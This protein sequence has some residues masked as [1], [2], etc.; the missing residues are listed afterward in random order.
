MTG[1]TQLEI[2]GKWADVR[3]T[4]LPHGKYMENHKTPTSPKEVP[5][6]KI[7]TR[8]YFPAL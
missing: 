7:F 2:S 6:S 3:I 4:G 8:L 5:V 1:S